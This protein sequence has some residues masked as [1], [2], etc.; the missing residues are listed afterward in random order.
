MVPLTLRNNSTST[1]Q[2]GYM[3][4]EIYDYFNQMIRSGTSTISSLSAS[5]T[6]T[7]SFD[8]SVGGRK[9]TFRI[10]YWI[11]D[12]NN[13]K[14]ELVYS[15]IPRPGVT[16]VDV[17]SVMGIHPNYTDIQLTLLERLGIKWA[18]V[19]SPSA[20]FRWNI[21]EPTEGQFV[22]YDTEVQLSASHN[23]KTLGTIGTNDY[24]PAWADNGGVPNLTKWGN[25]VSALVTHYKDYVQYWEIWNEPAFT[26]DFYAQMLKTASDSIEA[27][28]PTAKIVGMGGI[29]LSLM[30]SIISALDAR[31]LPGWDW[32]QHIDILSTHQYP[33]SA[34]ETFKSPIIDT[35][36]LP[37][38]N[39]ET[40]SWDKGYYQGQ[41]S[42]FVSYGKNIWSYND[43]KRFYDGMTGSA[44]QVVQNFV[45]SIGGGMT[46]YFY[47]DS[48]ITTAPSYFLS[49]PTI[50]EYDGTVRT[51]GIAYIIAGSFIDH[52]IGHGDYS[53]DSNS[54]M[55]LFDKSG[56]P[57]V[58]VF[59]KDNSSKQV[60]LSLSAGQ[61]KVYDIMGNEISISNSIVP[62]G[63]NVVYIVGQSISTT[64]MTTAIQSGVVASRTD[65]QAPYIS[66]SDISEGPIYD[67]NT[68]VRWVGLDDTSFPNLGE[69]NPETGVASDV[70]KPEALLYSYRLDP[71]STWSSWLP[72]TYV[73]YTDVPNGVY[74][75]EVK[76][77][78]EAGNVSKIGRAHV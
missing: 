78:D 43:A 31:Y 36:N 18:R 73:D 62:Y 71:Y 41:N 26:A 35:Y 72:N 49:H 70:P 23:I 16:G 29:S 19:L 38:W 11:K 40:G 44:N 3:R 13:T 28:D 27:N 5:T 32:R 2:S 14:R 75:F 15:V 12:T 56:V 8:L 50:L 39:T 64:T 20:F 33:G 47:Y 4:Y 59:S 24:W 61:F 42:N 34:P 65:T 69:I 21:V 9:G 7:S 53:P 45:R 1:A 68:R 6:Q 46:K 60:T 51:K 37:V 66:L 76:V 17:D 57:I 48:R 55:H 22:W 54:F 63:R 77:K 25:F 52:S 58:A 30:Q 10:V 74:Q 67:G